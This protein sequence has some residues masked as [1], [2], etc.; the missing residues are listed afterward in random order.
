MYL[1][2]LAWNRRALGAL[3]LTSLG[4]GFSCDFLVGVGKWLLVLL[5]FW[6]GDLWIEEGTYFLGLSSSLD[7]SLVSMGM[8]MFGLESEDLYLM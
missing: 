7:T 6:V 8:I 5:L 4:L 2:N 1:H 3:L